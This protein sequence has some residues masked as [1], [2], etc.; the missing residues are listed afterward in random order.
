MR[1]RFCSGQSVGPSRG[2]LEVTCHK[3]ASC[4]TSTILVVCL[5][6][7]GLLKLENCIMQFLGGGGTL[8]RPKVQSSF[9]HVQSYAAS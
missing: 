2:D 6:C 5:L 3:A 4:L 9:S 8:K 1:F 7:K